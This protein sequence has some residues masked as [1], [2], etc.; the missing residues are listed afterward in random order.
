MTADSKAPPRTGTKERLQSLD[1]LRGFD[2]AML[3]G[4]GGIIVALANLTGWG[5]MEVLAIQAEQHG[6]PGYP[7]G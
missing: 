6:Q 1:T 3:L 4:G 7:S 5:W 2:M